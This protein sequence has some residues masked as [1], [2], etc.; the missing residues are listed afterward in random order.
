MPT[1]AVV[2][3]SAYG[4][5]RRVAE[6]V[7]AGAA[8][9]AGTRVL[10]LTS[11]EAIDRLDELDAADAI[12]LGCPTYLG[13]PSADFKR[14]MDATGRKWVA[15]GWRDKLAAGFTNSGSYSGDKLATLQAF[16]V[17]AAQH[18]MVWVGQSEMPPFIKGGHGDPP[19]AI[20]R[21][22]SFLG[23]MTQSDNLPAEQTP[24]SG[25]LE[26]ARRFGMRIAT[27]ALRW[28]GGTSD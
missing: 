4:H 21:L 19:D 1:V 15:Q 5:T 23:L 27:A 18:G 10:L 8:E 28:S 11:N 12:V 26:T 20:N 17:L 2:Y 6:A 22:G 3:H 14:F 7:A 9:I 13:G 24:P 25:D 16:A